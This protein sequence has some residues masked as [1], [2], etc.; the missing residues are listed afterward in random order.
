MLG[1]L[2]PF[3]AALWQAPA[4][5]L[6]SRGI[7]PNVMT[8]LGT[9]G[10]VLGAVLFY[11]HGGIWLFWGTLFITFFVVT[12][13]L[14]GTMARLGGKSSRLGAFLDSTLDRVADA[15]IFGTLTWVFIDIDRATAL[16]ALLCLAI[17]SLVPYARA[18]AEGLGVAANFGLAERSDRLVIS[19]VATGFYGLGLFPL[20][21]LTGALWMLTVLAAITVGQRVWAVVRQARS[22]PEWNARLDGQP[23]PYPHE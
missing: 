4:R 16:G 1:R 5:F 17:G 8:V 11:P 14:D 7:H 21:V 9:V 3:M 20:W 10:V 15:A 19:L 2:R 6:L 13:M 12:D 22:H 18:K 23:Q